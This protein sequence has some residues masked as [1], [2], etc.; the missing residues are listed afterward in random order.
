MG[1]RKKLTPDK[2][3]ELHVRQNLSLSEIGNMFGISRQRVHQ[4][5]REYE[6]THG[7][8]NRRFFIDVL[9]L[10]H[11]LDLGWSVKQISNHFDM[12]TSKISRLIRKYQDEYDYGVS[13]IEIRK[14]KAND[15]ISKG[16]LHELYV[17]KLYTEKEIADEFQVSPSTINILRKQYKI[18]TNKDKSLR[19]LPNVLT[20]DK[21]EQL[22]L[23]NSYNLDEIANMYDCNI[24]AIL[25]LKKQYNIKK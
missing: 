10:K 24:V 19:K 13:N 20:K 16:R 4:L 12:T 17:D 5:K 9:T 3:I 22:Y 7:K 11:Y 8:I 23:R 6:R 2:L 21:F 15:I 18:P 14:K 25:K 1:I